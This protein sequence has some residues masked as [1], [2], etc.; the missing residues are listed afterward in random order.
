MPDSSLEAK[1]Q[2]SRE[3]KDYNS[4]FKYYSLLID[5]LRLINPSLAGEKSILLGNLYLEQADFNAIDTLFTENKLTEIKDSLILSSIYRLVGARFL[6]SEQPENAEIHFLNAL[7]IRKNV[8]PVGDTLY[9]QLLN[10]LA[11]VNIAL[12]NFDQAKQYL[13]DC[14][15]LLKQTDTGNKTIYAENLFSRGNYLYRTGEFKKSLTFYE[16]SFSLFDSLQNTSGKAKALNN[17]GNS[18]YRLFETERALQY[19]RKS[20]EIK[21][22]FYGP[23]HPQ[24]A[25]TQNNIGL[26][27]DYFGEPD[28]AIDYYS[29][30]LIVR[31]KFFGS[32]SRIVAKTLTNLANALKDFGDYVKAESLYT[33]SIRIFEKINKN[34]P[35][36]AI[37]AI[38]L[39][40]VLALQEKFIP[41]IGYLKLADQLL[42]K[43][44][45]NRHL[46]VAFANLNLSISSWSA[47]KKEESLLQLAEALKIA[48][49]AAQ[50]PSPLIAEIYS[51]YG[52]REAEKENYLKSVS[53]YQK[54]LHN[55]IPSFNK[56]NFLENPDSS[57]LLNDS[58]LVRIL[59]S[60]ADI[61]LKMNGNYTDAAFETIKLAEYIIDNLR[62]GFS[63]ESSKLLLGKEMRKTYETGVKICFRLNELNNY[64]V[65]TAESFRFFEKSKSAAL[66][67]KVIEN[68]AKYTAGIPDSLL[69][70]ER[71]LR[72][73]IS[74]LQVKMNSTEPDSRKNKYNAELFLLKT[75]YLDLIK[76]YEVKY[77][78][79]YKL[80]YSSGVIGIE[81]LKKD[82][83]KKD[84]TYLQYF[85]AGKE[86]YILVITR[87]NSSFIKV[88][89]DNDLME[90]VAGYRKGML[91]SNHKLFAASAYKLYE[92]LIKPV[93]G[94]IKGESVVIVPDGI[95]S[96]VSFD[97]L[98]D[99][100]D[101]GS[102]GDYKKLSYLVYKYRISYT[103][104]CS[105]LKENIS[106][107][108]VNDLK[109]I[110]GFAPY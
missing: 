90:D 73:R 14:S 13:D 57:Q 43:S 101:D 107:K 68:R 8:L 12:N 30:A 45:G 59:T 86:I 35:D 66:F 110:L 61:L 33:R 39:G 75:E 28:R 41:A 5:S 32:E 53:Y 96:L 21:I 79:Y 22:D 15:Q 89:L 51:E 55:M 88:P 76:T 70:T 72:T 91:E 7:N 52:L 42:R 24:T 26:V 71:R 4:C 80:K 94:F 11:D 105:L 44:Y 38:N 81:N 50:E 85:L 95:L 54:A 3:I 56:K 98:I 17:I 97:T 29:K 82:I 103:Y 18:L 10:D 6:Y 58:R 9:C 20:L 104:S 25:D 37:V 16:N 34:N 106:F 83:L 93:A 67:N 87:N 100:P 78:A 69:E 77:P 40:E 36:I 63:E 60:K 1:A 48:S 92:I 65:Y 46:W 19:F 109:S 2:Y 31:E 49:A 62:M 47:G 64:E 27:Y 74:G 84:E 102:S 108:S 23:D 99:K